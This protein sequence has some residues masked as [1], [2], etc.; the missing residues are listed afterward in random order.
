MFYTN[1]QSDSPSNPGL[2]RE[3]AILGCATGLKEPLDTRIWKGQDEDWDGAAR[4]V[5]RN[6]SEQR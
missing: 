4:R 1:K 2:I 6:N 3:I 5:E